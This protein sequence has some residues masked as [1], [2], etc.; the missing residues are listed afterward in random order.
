MFKISTETVNK[1]N[2]LHFFLNRQSRNPTRPSRHPHR[3]VPLPLDEC[4]H[5]TLLPQPQWCAGGGHK[6][7]HCDPSVCAKFG[8]IW[9]TLTWV[10]TTFAATRQKSPPARHLLC[11]S[12]MSAQCSAASSSDLGSLSHQL[13]HHAHTCCTHES[14]VGTPRS[15]APH[16]FAH[17]RRTGRFVMTISLK[18]VWQNHCQQLHCADM[19]RWTLL[20]L[21]E[22]RLSCIVNLFCLGTLSM[23]NVH[24][25]THT[26]THTHTFSI[27]KPQHH[28]SWSRNKIFV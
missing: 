3:S 15:C 9:V 16:C 8:V 1:L 26:H 28:N 2:F 14:K 10:A 17:S 4:A 11:R 7:K 27:T 6:H 21:C 5:R 23:K 19:Q 25:Q 24:T 13:Q 12:D 20:D 22:A 18:K